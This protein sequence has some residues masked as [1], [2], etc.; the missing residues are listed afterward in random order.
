[1]SARYV[2][3]AGRDWLTPLFDPALALTMREGRWRPVVA[4]LAV[5]AGRDVAEVGAGT[6]STSL[7]LARAGARVVAVDGDPAVLSIAQ[8]KPGANA[9]TWRTGMAGEL[10]LGTESFDA[11]VMTL[12][13]HHLD[14]DAKRAALAEARR[15]LRPGG[16]LVIADWGV[17]DGLVPRLVFPTLRVLDGAAGLEDHAAGRLP[18]IVAGA[19]FDSVSCRLRLPTVWGSLE[20]LTAARS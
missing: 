13:L 12:L 1:M 3:A 14:G 9:I 20:V 18:A 6:G 5:D 10:P 7:E 15:V 16:R 2:P 11:V 17:P 4:R 8:R 19:G